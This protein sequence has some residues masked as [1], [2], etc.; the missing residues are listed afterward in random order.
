[1]NRFFSPLIVVMVFSFSV[2]GC[3]TQS[4]YLKKV[5]ELDNK[6]ASLQ[7]KCTDE[8]SALKDKVT[9]L[10]TDREQLKEAFVNATREKEDLEKVLQSKS[11]ALAKNIVELRK[12]NAELEGENQVLTE[13]LIHQKHLREEEL[14]SIKKAHNNLMQEMKGEMDKGLIT[15][16]E[17]K[18]K[19]NLDVQEKIIFDSGESEIN[20]EGQAVLQRLIDIIKNV[21]DKPHRIEGH[22]DNI[23][24]KGQPSKKYPTSWELAA[25]R[26]IA[27]TRFFQKQGIDPANLT[28]ASYGE[29][30]PIADNSTSEGRA[31][32]RRITITLLP[33]E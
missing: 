33:T 11:D 32:N 15:V 26:A 13:N 2:S 23:R 10:T 18:G 24:I 17:S 12:K 7:Q 28:A 22:T 14:D 16:T 29:Y 5:G 6:F 4:T 3:V 8:N 30:S 25:A 9:T 1:M 21:W 19:L 20:T 31:R 27:V